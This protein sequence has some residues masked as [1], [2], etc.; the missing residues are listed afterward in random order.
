MWISQARSPPVT[1]GIEFLPQ[2]PNL[3]GTI[4]QQVLARESLRHAKTLGAFSDE[5][6]MAGML[7]D[8][9]RDHGNILDVPHTSDRTRPARGPMHAARIEFDDPFFIG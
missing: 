5:H 3:A 1:I 9:L 4:G 6:D 7:E 2:H 8:R